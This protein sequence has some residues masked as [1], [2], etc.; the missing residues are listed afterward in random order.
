V[1]RWLAVLL[2]AA[3]IW[4]ASYYPVRMDDPKAIYLTRD[5][6][7]VK[8]D[9]VTDD[10]AAIQQAIDKV[11]SFGSQG[12]VFIPE[13]R[14]RITHTIYV[15]PSIR[16]IGYGATRPVFLLGPNTPGYQDPNAE[17]YMVFFAGGRPGAAAVE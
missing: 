1:R 17:S 3:P 6:F 14:Y 11:Q 2:A 10:S 8:G 16:V 12:I 13:G 7:A 5:A 4:A 9:G 15:W